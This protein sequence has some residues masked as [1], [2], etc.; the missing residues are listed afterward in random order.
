M[1]PERTPV[2]D[3]AVP[4]ET[5]VADYQPVEFV[6]KAVVA[7]DCSVKEGG[8]ADPQEQAKEVIEKRSSYEL[9]RTGKAW[10]YDARTKR[11][12]NPRGRTGMTNRGLLGKWGPNHAADPIVTREK[13]AEPRKLQMVAIKRRDTGD[14]AIPGGMVDPHELVSVTLKREFTE[15]AC[16]QPT[17]DKKLKMEQLLKQLFA[18]KNGHVI[19]SGYVDDPRNTDNAWMETVAMHFHCPPQLGKLLLLHAGD[20]AAEVQWLDIDEANEHYRNLYASHK[21]MVDDAI[22]ELQKRQEQRQKAV[23]AIAAT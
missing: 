20:D 3:D 22:V 2:V 19:Y 5:D 23:A 6:H 11:P 13:P 8:W 9:E 17:T 4:W 12:L 15:E 7:N 16:A 18:E 1:Y 10:Q 21:G 14:W